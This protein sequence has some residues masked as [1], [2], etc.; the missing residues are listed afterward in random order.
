M[1]NPISVTIRK[2][3][4]MQ[5]AGPQRVSPAADFVRP[6]S[7]RELHPIWPAR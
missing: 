7:L 5:K 2:A 4:R 1:D 3:D 6:R